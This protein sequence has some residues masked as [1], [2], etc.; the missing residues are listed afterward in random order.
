MVDLQVLQTSASLASS[1]ITFENLLMEF[2]VCF[3]VE[4]EEWLLFSNGIEGAPFQSNRTDNETLT[5]EQW[6]CNG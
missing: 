6:T 2:A 3:G 5:S 1:A 4:T